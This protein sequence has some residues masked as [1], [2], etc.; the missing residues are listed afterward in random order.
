MNVQ[1]YVHASYLAVIIKSFDR[2]LIASDLTRA[3]FGISH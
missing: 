3:Y 2:I 1:P